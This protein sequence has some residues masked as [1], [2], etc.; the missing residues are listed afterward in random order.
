VENAEEKLEQSK[1]FK[2]QKLKGSVKYTG[3]KLEQ[4]KSLK[5]K[6]LKSPVEK[7]RRS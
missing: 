5:V 2:V 7:R 4:S 1:S 6:K 3:K